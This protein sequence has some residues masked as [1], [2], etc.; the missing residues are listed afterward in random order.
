MNLK[1]LF[2]K[3]GLVQSFID[4]LRMASSIYYAWTKYY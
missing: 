4:E 1:K 2:G 3:D